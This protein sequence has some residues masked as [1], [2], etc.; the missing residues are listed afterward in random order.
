MAKK[1]TYEELEQRVKELEKE[2]SKR[3]QAEE[4]LRESEEKY[5]TLFKNANDAIFI[6]DVE[7]GVLLDANEEAEQLIGRSKREIIIMHQ[8]QLHPPDKVEYYKEK[9]HKHI[10]CA[11]TADFDAEVVKKDGTTVPV[12][13]SAAIMEFQGKTVLQGIFRDMTAYKLAQETLR[14]SEEKYRSLVESTEDSICLVDRNCRYLF[15]NEKH[16]ARFGLPTDRMIGKTYGE[17]HSNE[18]T[19][20]FSEKVKEVFE[21]GK[22]L[23]Y[24]YRSKTDGGYFLRTLSPVKEP[25]GRTTAVTVVS[26]DITEHK[27]IEEDLRTSQQYARNVI[28]SSLDMIITVD[29]GRCI[30]EFNKA[31]EK[32][33]G[34]GREEVVGKLVDVLYADPQEGLAVHKKTVEQGQCV[35]EILNR[36]KNGEVFRGFLSASLL[37]D[38]HG[39]VVGVMGVSRDITEQKRAEEALL[40]SEERH[41]LFFENSPIGIIH[42]DNRGVITAVNDV[43]IAIFGSSREKLIGLDI[44]DIPH[45]K[46]AESV[47]KSLN[48]ELAY[49]EGEYT[50]YTAA[51][52]AIIKSISIPIIRDGQVIAGVG[53]I[54]DITER[55]RFEDALRESEEKFRTLFEDSR[56]AI[57]INTKEGKFIDV[58][59]SYLDLFGY[60]R[61]EMAE[62]NATDDY[63]NPDDRIRVC[64]ELARKGSV[65]D[66][67]VK[68]KKKDGTEMDCLVT[69]AARKAEDGSI[70]TY[71]GII[72]DI[73]EKKKLEAQL[74]R[75]QKMEAIGTLA[76]GVAHDLNNILSGLVS[77]PALLLLEITEDSPLRRPILT[78]KQS[79]QKAAAVVQDL[80]T[81]ARRGIAVTEA[82]NLNLIISAYVKSPEHKRLIS[83]H[84]NVHVRTNL[85][86]DLLN[87]L[88]SPAH[89]SKTVV[90]LISNAAEAMPEGG[91]IFISTENRYIDRAIRG[92]DH[93]EEGDY[94][95]LTVSDTGVGIT[96][97]DMDR[98]FEPFY[99]KKV[100]GRSG[101]GLG[102]AVVWGT[103]KDHKGYIDIESSEGKGTTFTLYFPVTR[104]ELV[105]DKALVSIEDYKGKG[106]SILV[107]DDVEEQREI[108]SRILKKLGY[109]VTT[110]A[111]GE[112][113]VD[114]LKD[115]SADLLILDMIMDPG[116]D[117][118]E[119]Y[120]RI[121]ELHPGQ[122]ALIASGFSETDR[123]KEAQRLG[124]GAY[125]KKP[126]LLEKIGLA[127][128]AELKR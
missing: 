9:F 83:F 119:T 18:E 90:N 87:I 76:G 117:G 67:E 120:K 71:Q 125:V 94:V 47:Y 3:K 75:A 86:A 24:E 37:F 85:E 101:T 115:N 110:V 95:L 59:Q 8:S 41:R 109:S 23:S 116:I 88:C 34:Y 38:P 72:R 81:L 111:S 25:V 48:G 2:A 122:K 32:T 12:C 29:N 49:Y 127:V 84:P 20:D 118:L 27:R 102:M 35:Q 33:F 10:Q 60:N 126:F 26:K 42:Y 124:A 108:A 96:S 52:S 78:I 15:M 82:V 80:L 28:D 123:V 79:G 112:E 46:L 100:M 99:T 5:R 30:V 91:T 74:E 65:K 31:A 16:L 89:L 54:E 104:K 98:I 103:V 63:A 44:N 45:I 56:D 77:Y 6:A 73:T 57:F 107:V 128:R 66:F 50:S 13:I 1:L 55:Q 92:Y 22:S 62:R 106:E 19:K 58:N 61:E 105:K 69:T 14:E 39:E 7:T 70:L 40:E 17:L 121:I 64:D 36:R 51:K 93:V 11:R 114:Y 43:M 97:T 4:A 68:H 53:I 21:T 113:A